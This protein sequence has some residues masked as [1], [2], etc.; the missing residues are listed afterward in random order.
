MLPVTV[1]VKCVQPT[2][3]EQM[4][5]NCDLIV[6]FLVWWWSLMDNCY[7]VISSL[8]IDLLIFILFN[9]ESASVL[10]QLQLFV[11]GPF[12][13]NKVVLLRCVSCFCFGFWSIIFGCTAP[14]CVSKRQ[15]IWFFG[16]LV[17]NTF[18][19]LFNFWDEMAFVILPFWGLTTSSGPIL[20]CEYFN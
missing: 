4:I 7:V 16:S 18:F 8:L 5:S 11:I 20:S 14:L 15:L 6:F 3:F 2:R 9:S 10:I 19:T 17:T 12:M 13:R 1:W